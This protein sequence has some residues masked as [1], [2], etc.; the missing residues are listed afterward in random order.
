M[1]LGYALPM[2]KTG[3]SGAKKEIVE[4]GTKL[5]TQKAITAG[6]TAETVGFAGSIKLILGT[7]A[8]YIAAIGVIVGLLALLY[9]EYTK[10]ARALEKAN[11]N[12]KEQK[13]ILNE[14]TAA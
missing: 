11:K 13:T 1:T 5:A 12:L 2:L 9:L 14:T 8:P 6:T 4:I 3:L 10:D 7:F